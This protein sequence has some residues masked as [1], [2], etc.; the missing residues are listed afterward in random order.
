MSTHPQENHTARV[1]GVLAALTHIDGVGFHGIATNL[2][3]PAPNIDHSWAGL[4]RNAL[5]A[6]RAIDWPDELRG[7]VERFST[8]AEPLVAAL[9]QRNTADASNTAQ[10]LHVSY[11]ALSDAGW[12]YLARLAGVPEQDQGHH[13]PGAAHEGH[14]H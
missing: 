12:S 7:A 3:G 8:A 9:A 10:E 5:I 1:P 4:V 6:V 11:H 2:T 13:H 14:S